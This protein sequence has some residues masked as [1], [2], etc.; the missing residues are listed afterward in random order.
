MRK[1]SPH[2]KTYLTKYD[3]NQY[4]LFYLLKC[5]ATYTEDS[6][7]MMDYYIVHLCV[8]W[9]VKVNVTLMFLSR[10]NLSNL[11]E[12]TLWQRDNKSTV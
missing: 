11:W 3:T 8:N 10:Y 5:S 7:T 6:L 1:W 2:D 4:T 9:E 12:E